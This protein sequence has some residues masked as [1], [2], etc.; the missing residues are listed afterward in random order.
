[1]IYQ[2]SP[3]LPPAE[4]ATLPA[5][6]TPITAPDK[7]SANP[8]YKTARH[9]VATPIPPETTPSAE[10][11]TNGLEE[12]ELSAE[13]ISDEEAEVLPNKTVTTFSEVSLTDKIA[14]TSDESEDLLTKQINKCTDDT[15]ATTSASLATS[16]KSPDLLTKQLIKCKQIKAPSEVATTSENSAKPDKLVALSAEQPTQSEFQLINTQASIEF[17]INDRTTTPDR[18]Q[19]TPQP[20]QSS[21]QHKIKAP[22]KVAATT[23]DNS[24][25]EQQPL[26]SSTQ[27]KVK[28]PAKVAAT[29]PDNSAAEQ[30]PLQSSTQ[31]KVKTPAKV[32]AK[33]PENKTKPKSSVQRKKTTTPVKVATSETDSR[34][35]KQPSPLKA[36]ATKVE[37]ARNSDAAKTQEDLA[38]FLAKQSSQGQNPTVSDPVT[39]ATRTPE[40]L[41]TFV[42]KQRSQTVTAISEVVTNDTSKTAD[43]FGTFLAKQALQENHDTTIAFNE[44]AIHSDDLAPFLTKQPP[45]SLVPQKVANVPD[46]VSTNSNT[47]KKS[48]DLGAFLTKQPPQSQVPQKTASNTTSASTQKP[49]KTQPSQVQPQKE[50][51]DVST[52]IL[53]VD[54]GSRITFTQTASSNLENLLLGVIINRREVGNLDV[55][56]QGNTLLLPLEDFAKLA[57]FTVEIKDGK[58]KLSTPLGVISLGDNDIQNIKGITYISD[59][60]IREKLSSKIEFNSLDL[61]LIIDLPWGNNSTEYTSQTVKLQPDVF[62]PN[63]GFSNFRQELNIV[64]N[65]GDVRLQSSTLLGGRL[66]GGLWR[67][68][69]NNN[70]EN[71]PDLSEYFYYKR[72]GGFLY[73][74]GR[75]QIG[76]N[77][78][79]N[80]LNLTGAQVGYTNIPT[81]RFNQNNSANE[82]LPRRSRPLQTFQGVAPP[83]SFVQ[84]RVSGIVVAQQQVG[85]DGRYEFIDVN[86]PVGQNNQIEVLIFDRNNLSVPS[87]IRSVRINSSDLLLPA[88]GNVQL[89]GVGLTGNLAQNTLFDDNSIDAGQFAG[90]YQVRQ[91]LSNNLTFEGSL[92]AIPNALQS[93]AGLVW[94]VANPVVLS[95]SVGNSFGKL[96]YNTD[97]DIQLGK[98]DITANSQSY[99]SGYR[100]GKN[101][102]E[103]LNHSAEVSYRFNNNFQLGFLARSR[104]SGSDSNEYISPTFSLRPF[105]N[106]YLSGRPDITG[107][108]LFN[109]FYQINRAAR[110]SL[111]TFGDRYTTN[112]N[113]DFNRSYQLSL[114]SNFGGDFATRYTATLNHNPLDI[115]QLSWRMG[116]AY[117]EGNFGPVVGATMQVLPGLF[118]R[119]EYQGIPLAGRRNNFGGF[120]DDRLTISLVSDLS[121]AGGRAVP[122]NFSSVGKDRGAI[123]GRIIFQ[124][125]NQGYDLSGASVRVMNNHNKAVGGATTDSSGNF[126]VGGLPEGVYRVE[127]D[128]EK[129]PVELTLPKT[130]RVAEVGMAGVTN[131][132]FAARLEYGLAGRITDVAGQPM[133]DVRVELVNLAGTEVLSAMTDEFGLYRVDGVPT[134]KYTLQVPPQEAIA[135]SSTLPKREVT[136]RNEFVYD[137]N[138]QLPISTAAKEIKQK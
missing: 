87:E 58:T 95:A 97:L 98:L 47:T 128:P 94:R 104:K 57:D 12:W 108:Y 6:D 26:Q 68:R 4:V 69:V 50:G 62:A 49:V 101:S 84:L 19:V 43:D 103:F 1:M 106:L 67:V 36:Q 129:L 121:F 21:T 53:N 125:E 136:I 100:N 115:R 102:S 134:G 11:S 118:A 78:L 35:L 33:T 66:A 82:L 79:L 25:A 77:P 9:T 72:N 44:T 135:N 105:S 40:D 10:F 64:N 5:Q 27:H 46:E 14:Q 132:D 123:A 70:F 71:S 30:Q 55:I 109:A 20:P 42:A 137:Q 3:P 86:L 29:T 127:V 54:N 51:V 131:L 116:L 119:V 120:G 117:S 28:A 23:P 34:R 107:Q 133:P 37:V 91:G 59:T 22:A 74:V 48:E 122:S 114:G 32:A 16:E 45:H 38:G 112:L 88:G 111:N 83:A 138:L 52:S 63:N 61:A 81:D 17:F 76:I 89:A 96:A 2:A 24:A 75:Q 92:Q 93:Q 13:G 56:R 15:T 80:S 85:F 7:N 18:S 65:S 31:H 126:F 39:I 99:P 124:G 113:Y 110:L 130:S 41:A 8:A 60:V 90:F 73:Q